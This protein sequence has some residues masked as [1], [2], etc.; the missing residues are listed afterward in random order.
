[1]LGLKYIHN[2]QIPD[3]THPEEVQ[4]NSLPLEGGMDL[5]IFF[6][7]TEYGKSG[8]LVGLCVCMCVCVCVCCAGNGTQPL[9]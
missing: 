9:V 1:V 2:S 3:I 5:V 4:L 6:Q 7:Q 8:W